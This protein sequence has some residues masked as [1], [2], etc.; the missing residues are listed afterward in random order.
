MIDRGWNYGSYIEVDPDDIDGAMTEEVYRQY[1][2][3]VGTKL[4][5]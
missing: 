3:L 5:E 1:D 4:G 2:K